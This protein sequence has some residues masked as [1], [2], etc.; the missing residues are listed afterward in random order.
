MRTLKFL[1]LGLLGLVLFSLALAN[2]GAVTLRWLPDETAALLRLPNQFD[3]PLFV[4]IF[5]AL[6]AG[7]LVG[8]VWEWFREHQYRAEASR[9]GREAEALRRK[10]KDQ[11]TSAARDGDDVLAL[12]D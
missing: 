12:L 7:I 11:E 10:L 4:V 2:R 5:L 6:V 9:K 3:M 1:F 8:L